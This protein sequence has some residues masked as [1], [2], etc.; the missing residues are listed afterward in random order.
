MSAVADR[1]GARS[2]TEL[3]AAFDR[4][5][6]GEDA[7]AMTALFADDAQLLFANREA[8]VGH[9]AIRGYWSPIFAANVTT[10]TWTDCPRI[11]LHDDRAYTVC[12]YA[13]TVRSR[14]GGDPR[15]LYGRAT[16][17]L[18]REP[19]GRWV[20]AMAM[21]SPAPPPNGPRR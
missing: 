3:L 13:E 21:N 19:D 1:A 20:I 4:A 15:R 16:F 9:D 6:G 7:D 2:P 10:D 12:D 8:A 5:L 11:E 18:R 17:F 14:V